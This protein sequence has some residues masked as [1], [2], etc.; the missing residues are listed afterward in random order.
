M[1]FGSYNN[2]P[3]NEMIVNINRIQLKN[4]NFDK[5]SRAIID[6]R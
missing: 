4:D 2:V 3:N 1:A 6:S 5:Y